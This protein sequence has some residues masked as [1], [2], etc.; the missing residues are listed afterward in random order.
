MK[1][2]IVFNKSKLMAVMLLLANSDVHSAATAAADG[3]S[4]VVTRPVTWRDGGL[5][6]R[7]EDAKDRLVLCTD[8]RDTDTKATDIWDAMAECSRMSMSQ[9]ECNA[10][11]ANF[12][13]QI[14]DERS[15]WDYN[16][17]I[18][19]G[20]YAGSTK[21]TPLLAAVASGSV[22]ATKAL[23]VNGA[24]PSL[25]SSDFPNFTPLHEAVE[26]TKFRGEKYTNTE[27]VGTDSDWARG[28]PSSIHHR[29]HGPSQKAKQPNFVTIAKLLVAHGADLTV[30]DCSGDTALEF[31]DKLLWGK[32]DP[33]IRKILSDATEAQ[34]AGKAAS[35]R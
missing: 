8:R 4:A 5:Y 30:G 3:E 29:P 31:C 12:K 27:I 2:H 26:R 14:N 18:H 32:P 24:N 21:F 22:K 20:H 13:S 7:A 9:A 1:D 35:S 10:T 6:C 19:L 16:D 11:I 34:A 33:E 17:L 25:R 28:L 23:L 15:A